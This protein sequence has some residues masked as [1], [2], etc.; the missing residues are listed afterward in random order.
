MKYVSI[1]DATEILTCA[2]E[3]SIVRAAVHHDIFF[4]FSVALRT[5]ERS[6]G[7]MMGDPIWKS[8]IMP[9]RRYRFDVSAAPLPF[10][11]LG[12]EPSK[13]MLARLRH[14][15]N[16]CEQINPD[17]A[18]SGQSLLAGLSA[19]TRV[20]D[21]PL[22]AQI[23]ERCQISGADNGA[24]VVKEPRLLRMVE[25]VLRQEPILRS[26][27]AAS[28]GDLRGEQCFRRLFVMG[29]ARWYP[30]YVFTAPRGRQIDLV[31]YGWLVDDWQ[32][33][34]AFLTGPGE[35]SAPGKPRDLIPTL[36]DTNTSRW[37]SVLD[38]AEILPRMDWEAVMQRIGRDEG[39]A[40]GER[41]EEVEYVDARLFLLE[42]DTA[43]AL[44]CD[45]SSM[46]TIVDPDRAEPA[47]VRRIPVC[48]VEPGMF[49]L[50]RT[51]GG[52][53]YIAEVADTIM[54]SHA[55]RAR[56]AQRHWKALLRRAV[57]ASSL[58]AVVSDLSRLGGR[59]P[60]ETNVRNW[61]SYRTIRPQDASDFRA[62]MCLTGLSD[63]FDEYW[64]TMTMINIAHRQAGH[65]IAKLLL[66]KVTSS[67]LSQLTDT[68]RMDF[69]LPG[70]A[71]ATLSALRVQSVHEDTVSMPVHRLGRLTEVGDVI[72]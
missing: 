61:M 2:A 13:E 19:L 23:K 7:D 37:S 30:D 50:V 42:G 1:A 10:N 48:D 67:D 24:V 69:A 66:K 34:A 57:A 62:I 14:K 16:I 55:S 12:D 65:R 63:Q 71:A 45:E 9:M 44:D 43:V 46:A 18:E 35:L 47:P 17:L 8:F 72:G 5:L 4:S 53:E 39:G 38:P 11:Y 58:P 40:G 6:L 56:E 49:V 28:V 15:L 59:R 22:L 36:S 3:L 60:N 32:P 52:G 33:A 54:G 64:T 20:P 41:Q 27:R 51:Q 70:I 29:P 21:N 26:L 25:A 68:G 31:R